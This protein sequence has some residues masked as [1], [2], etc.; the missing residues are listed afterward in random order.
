[1]KQDKEGEYGPMEKAILNMM[2]MKTFT[3]R[4]ESKTQQTRNTS[5]PWG[6]NGFEEVHGGA[7]R[8]V[9]SGA[10]KMMT[11]DGVP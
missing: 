1:M 2:I 11:K 9:C 4:P 3:M 8:S 5:I 7:G 10:R 6:R